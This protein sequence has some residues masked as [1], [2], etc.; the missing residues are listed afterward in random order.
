M[1]AAAFVIYL[2]H[3]TASYKL[4]HFQNICTK[5]FEETQNKQ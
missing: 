3:V 2:N 4:G 1:V 5:Y